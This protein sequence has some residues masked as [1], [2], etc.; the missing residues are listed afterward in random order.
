MGIDYQVKSPARIW[1]SLIIRMSLFTI[2]II[3]PAG[4]WRWWEAWVLVSIWTGYAIVMTHYLLR[5]DPALLAE[6]LRLL[7]FHKEQ[8]NWDKVI[9]LLFFVAGV[10]IYIVP[11]FDVM[12]YSWSEPLPLW[13]RIVA[14]LAHLPCMVF[15][16][17]VM[18]VNTYLAQVVR[19]DKARGHKVITTGPYS[20]VRHP[21]YS[22]VII[23]LFATP[24][25]LGSRYT[26]VPAIFLIMLLIIRTILEDRTLHN[27]LEG[28]PEYAEKTRYRLVPWI[29]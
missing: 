22:A 11:G 3:W 8:K 14:L 10:A 24:V 26:L 4:T 21:M 12:R 9:M 17:W 13:M 5:H 7:P 23:L 1:L 16:G 29:W 18:R 2:A 28:Y 25:A 20:W 19:I 6:R 27:E 15:L